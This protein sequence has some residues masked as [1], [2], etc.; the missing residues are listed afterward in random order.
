[1]K[2]EDLKKLKEYSKSSNQASYLVLFILLI[3]G[4][5]FGEVQKLTFKDIDY[6]KIPYTYQEQKQSHLIERLQ[7]RHKMLLCYSKCFE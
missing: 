2:H 4:G 5:R 6:E 7:S 3:T 1:M